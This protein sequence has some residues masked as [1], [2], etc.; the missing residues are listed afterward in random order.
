MDFVLSYYHANELWP[1]PE[2]AS[3]GM[4]ELAD[5]LLHLLPAVQVVGEIGWQSRTDVPNIE[6]AEEKSLAFH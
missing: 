6:D 4:I 3:F 5:D 1:R 2:P